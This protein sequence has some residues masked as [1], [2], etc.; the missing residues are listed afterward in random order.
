MEKNHCSQASLLQHITA[1]V[2]AGRKAAGRSQTAA[3]TCPGSRAVEQQALPM[4]A[5]QRPCEGACFCRSSFLP[6]REE[7]VCDLLCFC[8][9]KPAAG[10]AGQPPCSRVSS[11]LPCH[12]HWLLHQR[13]ARQHPKPKD[14]AA[15]LTNLYGHQAVHQ[16]LRAATQDG[17]EFRGITHALVQPG[18]QAQAGWSSASPAK[19]HQMLSHCQ[20]ANIDRE[21]FCCF[22]TLPTQLKFIYS[23][24]FF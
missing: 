14:C 19:L 16:C 8:R 12:G 18:R 17:S 2:F 15:E 13:D 21:W 20:V 22:Y 3:G 5:Q 1:T 23:F 4:P 10:G 24:I 6:G 11:S 9:A 7:L